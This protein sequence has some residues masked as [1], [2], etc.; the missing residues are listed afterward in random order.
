MFRQ[1]WKSMLFAVVIVATLLTTVER[2]DAWWWGCCGPTYY[3]C[4]PCYSVCDPCY[5]GGW[6]LGWRPGPIRRLVFG[7][8]R[9]YYAGGWCG[10]CCY[11]TYTCCN[12]VSTC[13]GTATTQMAPSTQTAPTPAK[14]PVIEAPVAPTPAAPETPVEPGLMPAPAVPSEPAP[15]LPGEIPPAETPTTPTVPTEPSSTSSPTPET[16]GVLTVWVPFD[17]KVTVNGLATRSMGSRR[18]FVSFGLK[19]GFS[20]K[21]EIH[22]EVSQDGKIQEDNR[23]VML[24]AGKSVGVTFGFTTNPVEQVASA[25]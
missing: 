12:E 19:P 20:Y 24:T 25:R 21:Y 16:S 13:C 1:S 7:P 10:S 11:S 2:A 8:C 5:S 14:K 9:W 15:A 17:A 18:Q 23:T 3:S 6:Y 22:A 4:S